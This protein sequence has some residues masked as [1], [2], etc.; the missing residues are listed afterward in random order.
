LARFPEQYRNIHAMNFFQEERIMKYK[1]WAIFPFVLFLAACVAAPARAQTPTG[2]RTS[3][4]GTQSGTD[5]SGADLARL[6]VGKTT[7]EEALA[8]LGAPPAYSSPAVGESSL[9]RHMWG[10]STHDLTRF[11]VVGPLLMSSM[12][13]GG[14]AAV[15]VFSLLGIPDLATEKMAFLLFDHDVFMGIEGLRGVDLP[16]DVMERLTPAPIEVTV[17]IAGTDFKGEN[18]GKLE[19]G[20]TTFEEAKAILGAPPY[21]SNARENGATLHIWQCNRFYGTFVVDPA[22]GSQVK[23]HKEAYKWASLVFIHDVFAGLEGGARGIDLPPE[24]RKRLTLSMEESNNAWLGKLPERTKTRK[25]K[26]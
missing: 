6:E 24:V 22:T 14:G 9:T 13:G 15:V 4:F 10:Y 3:P 20:K 8:I 12:P 16:P 1:H 21:I 25:S 5:F 23:D 17:R 19:I 2:L 18:L 26:P 11:T 7:Y